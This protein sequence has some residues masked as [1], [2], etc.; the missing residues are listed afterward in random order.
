MHKIKFI[1]FNEST[2]FPYEKVLQAIK[3]YLQSLLALEEKVMKAQHGAYIDESLLLFSNN[4][5]TGIV[6]CTF[7]CGFTVRALKE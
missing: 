4:K 3:Y 1:Y 6:K 2:I 5:S 7:W